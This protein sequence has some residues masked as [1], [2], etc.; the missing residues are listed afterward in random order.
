ME[1][2]DFQEGEGFDLTDWLRRFERN[3]WESV[4][5]RLSKLF[6]RQDTVLLFIAY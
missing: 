2:C 1:R 3:P 6:T 5:K 4:T